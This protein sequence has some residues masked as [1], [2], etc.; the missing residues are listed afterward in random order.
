MAMSWRL[1]ISVGLALI[2]APLGAQGADLVLWW[3]K[4][5]YSK[6]DEALHDTV[7]AFEQKT[8]K[9]VEIALYP[10][11]ELVDKIAKALEAGDPPDFAF[12]I[13]PQ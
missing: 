6:E 9:Q 8:G 2:L 12:G 3:N 10:D 1:M 7:A 5:A 4:A 11:D 13:Q